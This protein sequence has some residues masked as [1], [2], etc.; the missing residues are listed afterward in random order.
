MYSSWHVILTVI[1]LLSGVT[2]MSRNAKKAIVGALGGLGLVMIL[3]GALAHIYPTTTGIIIA[4]ALWVT[5]G[6]LSKYWNLDKS[7]VKKA[8]D[9]STE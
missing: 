1:L 3:L 2:K 4:I 8:S 9:A 6:I 5:S 7:K